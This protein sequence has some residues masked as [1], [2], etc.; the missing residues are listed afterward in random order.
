MEYRLSHKSL[1]DVTDQVD[2]STGE[3]QLKFPDAEGN[4]R[5]RIFAFYQTQPHYNNLRFD[6]TNLI[7]T[8]SIFDNGSYVVDHHSVR[9]AQTVINFWEDHMLDEETLGLIEKAGNYGT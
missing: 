4:A 6:N 7:S 2:T 8:D 9:G 5:Y 1:R 3:V